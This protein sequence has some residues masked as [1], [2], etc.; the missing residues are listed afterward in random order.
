MHWSLTGRKR[1]R[2]RFRPM[3]EMV[4]PSAPETPADALPALVALRGVGKQFG[5]VFALRGVD[6][7]L[8]AGEVH[9]LLGENGAGKSTL[10]NLLAG[11]HRPDEGEVLIDGS[12]VHFHGP[13]QSLAAG[14][15]VVHQE[16]TL[17]PDLSIA[18]CVF[19]AR[20][21]R[22][23]LGLVDW[24]E[25]RR[26]AGDAIAQLGI[27]LDP[28]APVGELSIGDQQLVEIAKALTLRSRLLVLD[29]PTAAL[30]AGEVER[31]FEVVG[32][33]REQGVGVLFISHRLEE[34]EA[35]ADRVTTL[36]DGRLVQ[37][38]DAAGLTREEMIRHMVGRK[39]DTL[40]PKLATEIGAP[41]LSVRGLTVAGR[42][43]DVS[44]EVRRGEILGFSGLVGAGRSE[45]ARAIF[46]VDDLDSGEIALDGQPV[47]IHRSAD[48]MRLGIAYVPEDR[49]EQG[50]IL[51]W[52]IARNATLTLLDEIAPRWIVSRRREREIARR[53][54]ERFAVRCRGVDQPAGTLSGGNQQKVVLGKWL[55]RQPRVLILDEPTRGVDIATKA[56]IH[57]AVSELAVSGMAIVLISSELPEVIGMSDR[58]LVF[59]EGRIA[60]EFAGDELQEERLM[61]AA[62][63]EHVHVG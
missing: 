46:G 21:P 49:R 63:G 61:A 13:A 51:D 19:A 1:F 12:P 14:I 30:S 56:E 54:V 45:V 25:M 31:L 20:Q 5:G 47:A 55:S 18:E 40:F 59:H 37:S 60:G 22:G 36:R 34:V 24:G 41:V 50:L 38:T 17:F 27:R 48:A 58:V 39:L 4:D 2:Y 11:I 23:R 10:V 16:P 6:L 32:R 43:S 62:T 7:D 42:F 52:S 33:L 29:E 53:E 3:E 26:A 9:A 15:A 57:R 44:F 35:I 28:R 8:R